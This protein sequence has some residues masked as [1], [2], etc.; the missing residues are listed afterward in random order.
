MSE[1]LARSTY[2]SLTS[3]WTLRNVLCHT[4][5]SYSCCLL[6]SYSWLT[7]F[8]WT[9]IPIFCIPDGLLSCPVSSYSSFMSLLQTLITSLWTLVLALLH[10]QEHFLLSRISLMIVYL[11]T[12]FVFFLL[13][14]TFI[15]PYSCFMPLFLALINSVS[16]FCLTS[17]LW[18]CFDPQHTYDPLFLLYEMLFLSYWT[19]ISN[20]FCFTWW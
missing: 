17:R 7:L 11:W 9:T 10:P 3:L 18:T 13:C 20:I 1:I 6:Y 8:L 15:N 19:F 4:V 14:V 5:H 12:L 2:F 16:H